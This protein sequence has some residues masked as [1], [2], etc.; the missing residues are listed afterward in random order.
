[1]DKDSAAAKNTSSLTSDAGLEVQG[2]W[3]RGFRDYGSG[4]IA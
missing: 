4:R 2:W 1:V 3:S